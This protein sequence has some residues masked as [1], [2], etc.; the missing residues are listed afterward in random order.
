MIT[1]VGADLMWAGCDSKHV[2][3]CISGV[4]PL[5][6]AVGHARFS[7]VF[8]VLCRAGVISS[9]SRACL[10]SNGTLAA[11]LSVLPGMHECASVALHSLCYMLL[12]PTQVSCKKNL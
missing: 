8:S 9:L 12:A 7:G 10:G 6:M 1:R 5:E 11:P 3:R 4:R 2:S